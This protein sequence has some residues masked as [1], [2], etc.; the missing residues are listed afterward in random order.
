M[1]GKDEG[2][3]EIVIP[4]DPAE[5]VTPPEDR[6]PPANVATSD[7]LAAIREKLAQTEDE[8][9]R[10]RTRADEAQRAAATATGAVQQ[11]I[12]N[13]FYAQEVAISNALT[14]AQQEVES[15]KREL[16]ERSA[17]G[18]FAAVADATFK[19]QQAANRV[20]QAEQQGAYL[21]EA[22]ADYTARA[23]QQQRQADQPRVTP[24]IQQWIDAHPRFRSDAAYRQAAMGAD[25]LARLKGIEVESDAYFTFV[26]EQLGE[27]QASGGQTPAAPRGSSAA[28]PPSRS[29]PPAAGGGTS[30]TVHLTALEREYADITMG[31]RYPD[32]AKRYAAYAKNKERMQ[33]DKPLTPVN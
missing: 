29:V 31:S 10:E 13:K 15:A 6:T 8:R 11:E 2:D 27:R 7:E 26:E 3:L 28:A 32:P 25:S 33:R 20:M 4:D 1:T 23:E 19:M 30:R 12:A 9:N 14:A 21:K 5:A 16:A 17:A 22:K 18:D 24:R